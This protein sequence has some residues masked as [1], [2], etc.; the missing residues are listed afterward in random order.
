MNN[1]SSQ[2]VKNMYINLSFFFNPKNHVLIE[3]SEIIYWTL[4][5]EKYMLFGC[6]DVCEQI[7]KS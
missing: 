3:D 4:S 7:S 1:T 6:L 2:S 5:T